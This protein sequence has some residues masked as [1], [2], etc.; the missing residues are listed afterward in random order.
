MLV[1]QGNSL[2]AGGHKHWDNH[3]QKQLVMCIKNHK[4][5]HSFYPDAYVT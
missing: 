2:D 3:F 1:N 4:N 5:I